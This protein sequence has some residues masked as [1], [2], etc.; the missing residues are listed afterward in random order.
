MRRM[1]LVA[2]AVITIAAL[3]L[4]T[5]AETIIQEDFNSVSGTGGGEFFLG[6]G[7][8][9]VSD[10]DTALTG[11]NA[12]AGAVDRAYIHAA[13]NGVTDAGVGGSG[14]GRDRSLRYQL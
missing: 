12:F 9:V 5:Q 14:A 2:V 3:T 13:A 4:S 6:G 8:S 7:E 1:S 11:E 10:W